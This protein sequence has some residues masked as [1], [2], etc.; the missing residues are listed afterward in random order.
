MRWCLHPIWGVLKKRFSLRELIR[1]TFILHPPPIFQILEISLISA[2]D[3]ADTASHVINEWKPVTACDGSR[4]WKADQFLIEQDLPTWCCTTWLVKEFRTLLSPF[5]CLLFNQSLAIPVASHGITD[6]P[7]SFHYLRRTTWTPANRRTSDRF[8]TYATCRMLLETVVQKQLQQCLDEHD[9][10]PT[11]QSAYRK[12]HSTETA[13][14][15]LFKLQWRARRYWSWSCIRSLSVR[16]K[17]TVRHCSPWSNNN[18][19]SNI[20]S[21]RSGQGVVQVVGLLDRQNFSCCMLL[22]SRTSEAVNV[23]CSVP[24]GSVLGPLLFI[25]WPTTCGHIMKRCG[26]LSLRL[27]VC[28]SVCHVSYLENGAR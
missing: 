4:C 18:N 6:T 17:V 28:L 13:V 26:C 10:M 3:I 27:S 7:S 21:Q 22:G 1:P 20:R 24:Q 2:Q 16:L 9:A 15:K 12:Y 23:T 11:H 14:L 19:R 8:Q 25:M 5:I